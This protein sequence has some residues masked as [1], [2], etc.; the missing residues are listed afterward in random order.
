M[1][2]K[3]LALVNLFLIAAIPLDLS[4]WPICADPV[5]SRQT[6]ETSEPQGAQVYQENI[7][8]KIYLKQAGFPDFSLFEKISRAALPALLP[9]Y[10]QDENNPDS[11]NI[12]AGKVPIKI[13][14]YVEGQSLA[15]KNDPN[16]TVSLTETDANWVPIQAEFSVLAAE[17]GPGQG[18]KSLNFVL[19]EITPQIP[20]EEVTCAPEEKTLSQNL[21]SPDNPSPNFTA[22]GLIQRVVETIGNI[23]RTITKKEVKIHSRGYLYGGKA[24]NQ[25]SEALN[26][27]LP[28]QFTP[29]KETSSGQ[30]SLYEVSLSPGEKVSA[31]LKYQGQGAVAERYCNL[32]R[33]AYPAAFSVPGCD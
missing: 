30:E 14:H 20:P 8:G 22:T 2:S 19:P 16:K 4:E 5:L 10:F 29:Q 15:E 28:A 6:V 7:S 24:L 3:L 1:K 12:P 9:G 27:F 21:P 11:L 26:S 32:L 17:F 33:G 31:T 18:T 13:K 25:Q 23:V